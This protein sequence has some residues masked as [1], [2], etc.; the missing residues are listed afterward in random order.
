VDNE[1][2]TSL[3]LTIQIM[4]VAVV[5]GMLSLFA[6]LGQS[7]GRQAVA[8]V[9]ETQASTYASELRAMADYGPVPTASLLVVL[10][11]NDT[12]VR[13][14]SGFAYGVAITKAEDLTSFALLSKKVRVS[15]TP[16]RDEYDVNIAPE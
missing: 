3:S 6:T 5:V 16:V 14:V 15:L 12:A 11:K 8:T 13:Q 2:S 4:I 1:V 7:F 9:A 10:Q